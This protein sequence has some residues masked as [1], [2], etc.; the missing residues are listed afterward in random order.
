MAYKY[1]TKE[2]LAKSNEVDIANIFADK[3]N[4]AK[5][6]LNTNYSLP[7]IVD[8]VKENTNNFKKSENYFIDLDQAIRRVVFK[9]YESTNKVNPFADSVQIEEISTQPRIPAE[10]S[11]SGVKTGKPDITTK[12]E[13]VEEIADSIETQIASAI[14]GIKVMLEID[15]DNEE[16]KESLMQLELTLETLK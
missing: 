12:E 6:K 10:V 11:T 9:Y 15:P 5:E 14:E 2:L 16:Y 3:Q 13:I 8:W 7:Q 4:L 1:F